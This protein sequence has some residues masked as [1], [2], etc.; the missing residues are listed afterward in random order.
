LILPF[1]AARLP[2]TWRD[3]LY[4]PQTWPLTRLSV[5]LGPQS[6]PRR[7]LSTLKSLILRAARFMRSLD[8][9]FD[10]NSYAD[11]NHLLDI[12]L[13]MDRGTKQTAIR[14]STLTLAPT[15]VQFLSNYVGNNQADL[16]LLLQAV[17]TLVVRSKSLQHLSLGCLEE[18]LNH[19]PALLPRLDPK[20]MLSLHLS[21]V[22]RD[23]DYYPVYDLPLALLQPF[24]CLQVLSVDYDYVGNEFLQLLADHMP[25]LGKLILNVHG[26]DDHHAGIS[27]S[28]WSKL[29]VACPHLGVC[30]NL[31]HTDDSPN[32]LQE[33]LLDTD[34]PLT[35]F[36]ACFTAGTDGWLAQVVDLIAV[37]HQDTLRS[38]VL[39]DGLEQLTLL[40]N[41][42]FAVGVEN[43]LVMLA[44]RCRKLVNLT[45]IGES[46]D[47][48]NMF[49]SDL[50]TGY[51]ISEH[52]LIAISRLR[53]QSLKE[54]QVPSC[55][56]SLLQLPVPEDEGYSDDDKFFLDMAPKALREPILG[57]I[58][59]SLNK[60][61]WSPIQLGQ[62]PKAICDPRE[63]P[64]SAYLQQLLHEQAW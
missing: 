1:A 27:K 40:P 11:V 19:M 33:A 61:N 23:P 34:L 8:V 31:L 37:R 20:K 4:H 53:G 35:H 5:N 9:A 39:M 16:L 60:P 36:R 64:M 41:P 12:L 55:C 21:T 58:R 44:W 13:A 45:L 48:I 38:L 46:F 56:I 32:Q 18:L 59:K 25:M 47:F 2:F 30:L 24:S 29:R 43:P 63:A 62:L 14:L 6:V 26:L 52:D 57:E 3:C 28:S 54:L 17:E 22:K 7:S 15:T 10:P 50:F 51:E 42:S 49:H